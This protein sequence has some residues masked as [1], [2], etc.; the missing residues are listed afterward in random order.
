MQ[1]GIKPLGGE[2]G[3]VL[4]LLAP[5]FVGLLFGA[6]GSVLA[7][8]L[9]SLLEWDLISP[10]RWAGLANYAGLLGDSQFQKAVGV[11]LSFNLIY[12]P[13]TVIISLGVALLLNRPIRGRAIFRTIY[14]LPTV[15]SAVAVGLVWSW[16]YGRD[17]GLLNMII[18]GLGGEG[19]RWLGS[20]HVLLAVTAVNIWGAVGTGMVVFLAGLQAIPREY[21]ESAALDGASPLDQ[22]VYITM[23][24]ITPSIFF[25]TILATINGFQAFE[26][27]YI[28]TR[29]AN[30][31]SNMPTIVY[32]IYRNGF[33]FFRMGQASAQAIVLALM[34]FLLTLAYF[35]LERRWVVYE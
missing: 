12:V 5:T 35:W 1:S 18:E 19:V 16:I 21:Y 33:T 20:D 10:P 14:F 9:I 30:G 8:A 31:A 4:L 11:T 7:T 27:V 28:L 6:L 25:Q 15:S 17:R 13:G 32:A 29:G 22:L 24:L 2:R 34:I 3:W 23:P 26:Y